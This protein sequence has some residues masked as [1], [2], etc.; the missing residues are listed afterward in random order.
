[1]TEPTDFE[2]FLVAPPGLESTLRDELVEKRFSAP[3]VE[4]GGVAIRGDWPDV[5]RA[6]LEIRGASKVLAR[7]GEFRVVHLS[8]L[9]KLSRRF[10]WASI[11]RADVPVRVQATC[12]GSKIYH[13]KAAAQ[14]IETAIHEE[15]GAPIDPDSELTIRARIDDNIC[16]LSIDTSGELLHKRG[17]KEAVA[18]APMRENLAALFLRQMGYD[19][20]QTVLDP[21]CGSGTFIIEAAEIATGLAPGRSRDFAFELLANFDDTAWQALSAPRAPTETKIRFY[22]SDRN[23]AAIDMSQT[24]AQRAGIASLTHFTRQQ[25]KDLEPPE[26]PPGIVIINPPYGA[27]IGSKKQLHEVYTAIG[28]TLMSRFIGWRVGI[29]T[30]GNSLARVTGLPFGKPGPIIDHG[31]ISIRLFSTP[32]LKAGG[33]P[34]SNHRRKPRRRP[35]G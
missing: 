11:L 28:Q 27:R 15:L 14:R 1:M 16:T 13:A 7:I 22:G 34:R 5:W 32:P 18:K 24:N 35:T 21:M 4:A 30:T 25:V 29:I 6:N 8:Q 9:D 17:H 2:I 19:G 31:G 23:S 26:G 12:K 3:K 10:D 33:K 20:S